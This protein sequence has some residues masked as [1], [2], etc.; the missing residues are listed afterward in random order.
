MTN[1][2]VFPCGSEIGLE[3]HNSLKYAKGVKL[4]GASSVPDH[5]KFVYRNYVQIESSVG[6]E[7]FLAELRSVVS[8]ESIDFIFP[9][10]DTLIEALAGLS[11]ADLGGATV[12]G[13]AAETNL[14]TRYKSRTYE[15]LRPHRFVPDTFNVD[16][17]SESDFPVFLKPDS[18]Y[19]S[20]GIAIAATVSQ[21]REKL[22]A[23]PH[24]IAVEYLPGPEYTV[25]CFTDRHGA[26]RFVGPR[27]RQRIKNG[28]AVSSSTIEL[29]DEIQG[30]AERINETLSFRGQW[31]FQVKESRDGQLKLLEIGPRVA[32]TMN[33][34]R[35]RGVNLPLLSLLDRQGF[36]VEI[37]DNGFEATVDRALINRHE[38]RFEY[39]TVY[40]DFDDTLTLGD[41]VNTKVLAY[42]YQARNTGKEIILLTR[43]ANEL[44]N[45]LHKMAISKTLFTSIIHITDGT[46]KSRFIDQSDAVFIDDSFAERL[47]VATHTKAK[48]FDV[49]G[50]ESLLDWRA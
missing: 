10:F 27:I 49:D 4:I 29:T 31:F 50:V 8:A 3:I 48:V 18:G 43:H 33:L 5:G 37:L 39:S 7:G 34:Y 28:I 46:P 41:H 36:D 17:V 2:L 23:D 15:A 47:D 13:S 16:S 26:L 19:G 32:G 44:D 45:T 21:L 9:A 35:N 22:D 25:D 6:D 1:V 20:R 12:I 30:I 42:L 24:L 14:I 11:P 38:L 40:I